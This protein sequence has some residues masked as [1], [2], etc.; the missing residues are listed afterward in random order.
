MIDILALL[1]SFANLLLLLKLFVSLY[2]LMTISPIGRNLLL[3]PCD[4][5]YSTMS[6]T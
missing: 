2:I 4:L 1:F 3:S 6:V 5:S